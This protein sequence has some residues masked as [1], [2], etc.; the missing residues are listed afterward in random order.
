MF[1]H[2]TSGPPC[3]PQGA[4][5]SAVGT[6][7]KRQRLDTASAAVG[8]DDTAMTT[9]I[10]ASQNIHFNVNSRTETNIGS[11]DETIDPQLLLGGIEAVQVHQSSDNSQYQG[12][13]LTLE[14]HEIPEQHDTFQEQGVSQEHEV[15]D[16]RNTLNEQT[17]W[18]QQELFDQ[19]NT[20]EPHG[21]E[22]IIDP[23]LQWAYLM[24][25]GLDFLITVYF[26]L[27]SNTL[28]NH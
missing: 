5:E 28:I 17:N 6:S 2:P 19:S 14:Q 11:E 9:Q 26:P 25:P 15:L 1:P 24:G 8:I 21:T 13:K 7:T 27:S 3:E 23:D 12:Q 20:Y 16:P 4:F 22:E 18:A 10:V